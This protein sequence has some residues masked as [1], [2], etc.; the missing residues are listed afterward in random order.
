[1]RSIDQDAFRR[2]AA[3]PS[4]RGRYIIMPGGTMKKRNAHVRDPP[5]GETKWWNCKRGTRPG[6]RAGKKGEKRWQK[7]EHV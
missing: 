6:N 3:E 2:F 5:E 7:R 4:V 1:M